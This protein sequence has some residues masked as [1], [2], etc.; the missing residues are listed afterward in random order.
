MKGFKCFEYLKCLNAGW[1]TTLHLPNGVCC[2]PSCQICLCRTYHICRADLTTPPVWLP[3]A[4]RNLPCPMKFLMFDSGIHCQQANGARWQDGGRQCR[5]HIATLA[6]TNAKDHCIRAGDN[7]VL[8]ASCRP[9]CIFMHPC[10]SQF[11][12]L[13]F[14]L[15]GCIS[16]K[17]SVLCQPS[18][19]AVCP[20]PSTGCVANPVPVQLHWI[21]AL[22]DVRLWKMDR[23]YSVMHWLGGTPQAIVIN[24]LCDWDDNACR[25]RS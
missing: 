23:K 10:A 3:Q 20:S 24:Y 19:P 22:S 9:D 21:P 11:G 14:N 5:Y 8:G 16:N 18:L 15:A 25:T 13:H 6:Y 1:R 2:D 7:A 17:Q 4:H 12:G